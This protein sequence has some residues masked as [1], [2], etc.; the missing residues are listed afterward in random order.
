MIPVLKNL[1]LGKFCCSCVYK[2]NS[3]LLM[4][5]AIINNFL[6]IALITYGHI[7]VSWFFYRK[8]LPEKVKFNFYF[9]DFNLTNWER[10]S[11]G[12]T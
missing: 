6:N 2:Y 1:Q 10:H 4:A 9:L 11:Y 7:L 3:L 12:K 5:I 8:I